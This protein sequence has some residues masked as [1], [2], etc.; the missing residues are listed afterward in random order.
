M[1]EMNNNSMQIISTR[2]TE[3]EKRRKCLCVTIKSNNSMIAFPVSLTRQRKS[4]RNSLTSKVYFEKTKRKTNAL[5]SHLRIK[6]NL[7][8]M[9]KDEKRS[10][11]FVGIE[12]EIE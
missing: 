8:S 4:E 9:Y 6:T 11:E 3:R 1:I 12:I 2:I 7:L 5:T 10:I